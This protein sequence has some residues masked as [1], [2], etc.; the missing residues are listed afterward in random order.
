MET[1]PLICRANNKSI[2]WLLCGRDLHHERVKARTA[3][4]ASYNVLTS[5]KFLDSILNVFKITED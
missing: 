2:D 1:S 3:Y 5:A 4:L